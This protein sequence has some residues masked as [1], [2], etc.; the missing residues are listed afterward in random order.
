MHRQ[1]AQAFT[2]IELLVVVAMIAVLLALLTPALDKA[3]YQAELAV[4]GAQMRGVTSG[5]LTYAAENKRAYPERTSSA[6]DPSILTHP[7]FKFLQ[8]MSTYVSLK[9]FTDPFVEQLNIDEIMTNTYAVY[10]AGYSVY[11]GWGDGTLVS[12]MRKLG[13]RMKVN[14]GADSRSF[15]IVMADRD[16]RLL[17][18]YASS[19]HPDK[20][21]LMNLKVYQGGGNP[22]LVG[23]PGPTP[24]SSITGDVYVSWWEGATR[25][26]L[27]QNFAFD[28][29]S[30]I[31]LPDVPIVQ[32][33]ATDDPRITLIPQTLD[34]ND[35]NSGRRAQVPATK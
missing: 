31:R 3:I 1:V 28:D 27:D 18:G 6:G 14:A 22:W 34:A 33:P 25:G 13:D 29:N 24:I 12:P 11:L 16:D 35:N 17:G 19:T 5:A 10:Y 26:K 7:T 9:S 4:C 15:G 20:D 21:G 2:L 30:V 32:D 8:P 23:T